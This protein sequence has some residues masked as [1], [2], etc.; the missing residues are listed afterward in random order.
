MKNWKTIIPI[1]L[2]FT[3]Q[4]TSCRLISS[5]IHDEEIVAEAAGKQLYLSELDAV[6]PKGLSIEDSTYLA[7]QYILS[8]ASNCIYQAAAERNLS[9]SEK[10][11]EKE[12]AD[13]RAS[14]LKYRYEKRYVNERLDTVVSNLEIETFYNDNPEKFKLDAP[15]FRGRF[16]K[17]SKDSP[18]LPVIKKKMA[19]SD[20][21]DVYQADSLAYS[22]AQ[23]FHAWDDQ[24][25]DLS[26]VADEF[27]QPESALIS[28]KK[29]N[30]IEHVDTLGMA[31]VLYVLEMRL[32]GSQAPLEYSAPEIKDII[33][34]NR[35]HDLVTG[36]ERDLLEEARRNGNFVIY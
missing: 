8:W 19:S 25:A 34:S 2:L 10:N 24:W 26:V 33:I 18:M 7:T 21:E 27:G 11:V 35:K 30:W 1:I 6:M 13:Y 9:D 5:F 15:V 17:I 16:L 3:L 22:S 31:S 12:L 36:L 14:L 32:S 4:A 20:A 23:M 28:S 29:G